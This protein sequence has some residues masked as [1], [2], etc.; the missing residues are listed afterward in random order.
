MNK[1]QQSILQKTTRRAS[2]RSQAQLGGERGV[3]L[4]GRV[5]IRRERGRGIKKID[6]KLK[7]RE[8]KE[9]KEEEEGS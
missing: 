8:K 2:E 7:R 4:I 5:E 6:Q 1:D 9:I 3:G